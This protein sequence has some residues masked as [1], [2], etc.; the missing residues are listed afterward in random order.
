MAAPTVT[1]TACTVVRRLS[2]ALVIRAITQSAACDPRTPTRSWKPPLVITKVP[3][4][5][6]HSQGVQSVPC[7]R[8]FGGWQGGGAH[9]LQMQACAGMGGAKCSGHVTCAAPARLVPQARR[10][11]IDQIMTAAAPDACCHPTSKWRS[12]R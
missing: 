6:V 8:T 1:W 12:L 10:E 4:A 3:T 9:L 5:S 2:P 11:C 7:A